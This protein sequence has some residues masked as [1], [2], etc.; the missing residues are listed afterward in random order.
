MI[1]FLLAAY[2]IA[3]EYLGWLLRFLISSGRFVDTYRCCLLLTKFFPLTQSKFKH[4]TTQLAPSTCWFKLIWLVVSCLVYLFVRRNY[5]HIDWISWIVKKI[6]K[7]LHSY[8]SYS[9]N[10]INGNM[11]V[12]PI[13]QTNN[14]LHW[15]Q[16]APTLKIS[17]CEIQ[18][19]K[20]LNFSTLCAFVIS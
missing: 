20:N 3:K 19:K 6:K 9:A 5:D 15:P 14:N 11:I 12:L 13:H 8:L 4:L 7:V 1:S 17:L 16:K 2:M 18:G 10:E